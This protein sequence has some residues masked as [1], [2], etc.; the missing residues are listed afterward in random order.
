MPAGPTDLPFVHTAPGGTSSL[1]QRMQ[2]LVLWTLPPKSYLIPESPEWCYRRLKRGSEGAPDSTP[3]GLGFPVYG[4]SSILGSRTQR[5]LVAGG[6]SV[7]YS[8][9]GRAMGVSAGSQRRQDRW[10]SEERRAS[11]N[12]VWG[13]PLPGAE[14]GGSRI[15]Q[16]PLQPQ[17]FLPTLFHSLWWLRHPQILGD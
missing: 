1:P 2:H 4:P 3:G 6:Y 9:F 12:I 17:T 13:S 14:E 15:L 10:N 5:D 8:P 16:R 11:P 7:R